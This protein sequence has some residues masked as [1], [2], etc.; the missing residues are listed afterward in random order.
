MTPVVQTGQHRH[1][2]LRVVGG[3][4]IL[5]AIVAAVSAVPKSTWSGLAKGNI[6]ALVGSLNGTVGQML[7]HT[8][9]LDT[10]V[11]EAQSQLGQLEQEEAIVQKQAAT[12]E[13]LKQTLQ[14]QRQLTENG[15]NLMQQILTEETQLSHTT[16]QVAD[17]TGQL[18]G[19]VA[20][21]ANQLRG[22]L[23]AL[24]T[25]NQESNELGNQLDSMLAQ[26][27]DSVQEFKLF[28]QVDN[29]LSSLLGKQTT[30]TLTG[31]LS[32]VL[33]G[34]TNAGGGGKSTSSKSGSASGSSSA[35]SSSKASNSTPS[36]GSGSSSN[37][38]PLQDLLKNLL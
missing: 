27:N 20:A 4:V 36:S 32:S 30:G 37:S 26:L 22:L 19:V 34:L 8:H 38:N 28:G 24:Q 1:K 16:G 9:A 29:L 35:G 5:A 3:V 25:S 13:Q 18:T 33:G 6:F 14:T 12:G 17:Q 11:Q 31:G 2:S 23:G 7:Q 10:Q 15:V 21:N